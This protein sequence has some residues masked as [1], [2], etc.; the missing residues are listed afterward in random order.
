MARITVEDCLEKIDN[1]YDLVLIAKEKITNDDKL[2][3]LN[4]I[5]TSTNIENGVK[6]SDLVVEAA[7][8][9]IDLKPS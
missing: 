2:Q 4:N 8:E 1:Q 9:N 7:T 5:T 6:N 3:T